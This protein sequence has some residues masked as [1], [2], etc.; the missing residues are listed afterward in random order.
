MSKRLFVD[1]KE[2]SRNEIAGTVKFPA[3][4]VFVFEALA[5]VIREFSKACEVAPAEIAADLLSH[6]RNNP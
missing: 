2:N 3:D 5:E 6:I 4:S 1:L